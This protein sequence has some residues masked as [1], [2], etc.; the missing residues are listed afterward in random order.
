MFDPLDTIKLGPAQLS[1]TMISYI[2][3]AAVFYGILSYLLKQTD[4]KGERENILNLVTT[5]FVIFLVVYKLWPF[6]FSPSL[7]LDLRNLIYYAGGP[8]AF[9]GAGTISLGFF[10]VSWIR[11]RWKI[12]LIDQLSISAFC[13]AIMYSVLLKEVGQR[14]HLDFGWKVEGVYFHPVNVYEALLLLVFLFFTLQ[15]T[16]TNG[17]GKSTI[18]LVI[19][20]ILVKSLLVPF[21][22]K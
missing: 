1:L 7:L 13:S 10:I 17:I 19:T 9:V 22:I 4:L 3:C 15:W 8:G 12:Q 21:Q 2:I 11:Q 20:F 6:I 14:N 16:R 18:L 5:T